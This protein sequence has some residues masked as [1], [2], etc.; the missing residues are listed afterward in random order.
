M[1]TETAGGSNENVLQ[2]K[3]QQVKVTMIQ[4]IALDTVIKCTLSVLLFVEFLS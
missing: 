2:S 3:Y 4:L 1:V